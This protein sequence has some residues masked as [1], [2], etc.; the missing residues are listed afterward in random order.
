MLFIFVSS[1]LFVLFVLECVCC[2][3]LLLGVLVCFRFVLC[4]CWSGLGVF[5]VLF[6]FGFCLFF[7]F[8]SFCFL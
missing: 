3:F 6:F 5:L 7:V 8:V 1:C 4:V 2:L